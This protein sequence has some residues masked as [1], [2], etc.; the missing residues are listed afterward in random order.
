MS[1][2]SGVKFKRTENTVCIILPIFENTILQ[3]RV[4]RWRG[5]QRGQLPQG[6]KF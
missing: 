3:G 2:I 1:N 4:K 6:A 5:G